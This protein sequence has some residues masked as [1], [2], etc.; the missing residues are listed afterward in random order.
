VP[1]QR[2]R[3]DLRPGQEPQHQRADTGQERDHGSLGDVLRLHGIIANPDRGGR[4]SSSTP[5]VTAASTAKT[6]DN[7]CPVWTTLEHRPATACDG[8]SWTMCR[9]TDLRVAV[10]HSAAPSRGDR[11][12]SW[13]SMNRS[14]RPCPELL[15]HH[16][17]STATRVTSI[18]SAPASG[19]V[20]RGG[21]QPA[22]SAGGG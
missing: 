18:A 6:S 5:P 13:S 15:L 14:G 11:P 20:G 19:R 7:A 2:H 12:R 22:S 8:R 9:S 17:P 3:V 16:L 21:R 1:A 10:H 4:T